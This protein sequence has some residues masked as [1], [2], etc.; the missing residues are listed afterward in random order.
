MSATKGCKWIV[1]AC[2]L[3]ANGFFYLRK[4]ISE[5]TCGV[6]MRTSTNRLVGSE[7]VVDIMAK[8][9]RDRPLTRPT[10]VM[11]D[12]KQDY[13]LDI[14]YRVAWLGVEKAWRELFGA[15]SISFDHLRWYSAAVMEH[16]P[17]SYITLEHDKQTHRFIR[18]FI[19]FKACIDGFTHCRPLLFLDATF[20]KGHFK[21]FLLA[22][23]AKDGNQVMIHPTYMLQVY[24][25]S[26]TLWSTR[27]T[28][29][30]SHGFYGI[31]YMSY[32]G[33]G[34]SHSYQIRMPV[35]WMQC[36]LFSPTRN[37][38]FVCNI[39]KE[40]CET[41][42]VIRTVCIG[43]GWGRR[44]G[45]MC[46]NAAESFNLWIR[47]ARNLPITRLV[48]S[49]R[50]KIMRQMSKRRVAAQTWAGTICPKME[51]RLERAFNKG[52]S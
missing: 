24:S 30:T 52:R 32:M 25:H 6:A 18:F 5:H 26:H 29:K 23:T 48:D 1:H 51:S 45:E 37:M 2:K 34:Q 9:I 33:I 11:L 35:Y 50:A 15:H 39:C 8:R 42:Y 13:G 47:E 20:L 43:L 31:S 10:E 27:R 36:Q 3:E 4:W 28:R 12:M 14:T 19:S 7:L 16:N 38:P 46:S 17:G 49:I 44:Y 21:G 41:D 22:A 40:I